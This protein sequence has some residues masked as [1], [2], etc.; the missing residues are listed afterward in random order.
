MIIMF[1]TDKGHQYGE[2][3]GEYQIKYADWMRDQTGIYKNN[4]EMNPGRKKYIN[5]KKSMKNSFTVILIR[6]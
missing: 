2:R 1:T 3:L 6:R 4:K 5:K